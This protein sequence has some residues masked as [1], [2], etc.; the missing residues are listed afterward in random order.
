MRDPKNTLYLLQS[1]CSKFFLL[2]A[3]TG[4]ISEHLSHCL[5]IIPEAL[6]GKV[7][8]LSGSIPA[9]PEGKVEGLVP[10]GPAWLWGLPFQPEV[11]NGELQPCQ[12]RTRRAGRGCRTGPG[13]VP[14]RSLARSQSRSP[15]RGL[16]PPP[17]R[18]HFSDKTPGNWAIRHPATPQ[19]NKAC[20]SRAFL[21]KG[22]IPWL[23]SRAPSSASCKV[24]IL[25]SQRLEN[26]SESNL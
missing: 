17:P 12:S 13:A 11:R 16:L 14:A 10:A 25:E 1:A 4:E 23:L 20:G 9:A 19:P 6:C 15:G 2:A 18:D 7:P 22:G 5:I 3:K 8:F 26:T 24:E 21:G